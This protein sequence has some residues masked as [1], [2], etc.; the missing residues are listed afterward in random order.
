MRLPFSKKSMELFEYNFRFRVLG[1]HQD[2]LKS[3]GNTII[4]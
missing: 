2:L 4:K 3:T 1:G